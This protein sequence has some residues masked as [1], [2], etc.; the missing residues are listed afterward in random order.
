MRVAVTDTGIGIPENQV[1]RIFDR[2]YQV[3]SS[4]TRQFGGTGLG[5][6]LVKRIVEAHGSQVAV[7]SRL[8]AGST[9]AF[10]LPTA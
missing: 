3:D 5:L 9:F 2:F 10:L 6:T 8:G 1:P 4:T 7:E